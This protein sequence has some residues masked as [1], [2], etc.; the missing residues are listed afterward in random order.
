MLVLL[1]K[2][3]QIYAA[4]ELKSPE[5]EKPLVFFNQL[6]SLDSDEWESSIIESA[7][8]GRLIFS[9]KSYENTGVLIDLIICLPILYWE[10]S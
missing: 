7:K 1:Q 3:L 4:K 6:L 2:L 5:S 8:S 9:C 10:C